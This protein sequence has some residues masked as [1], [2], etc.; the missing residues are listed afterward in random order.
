M[1]RGR[2]DEVEGSGGREAIAM[3]WVAFATGFGLAELLTSLD[4]PA[5]PAGRWD[6][7]EVP[8]GLYRG[9]ELGV[10]EAVALGRGSRDGVEG[11]SDMVAGSCVA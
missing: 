11:T 10:G 3:G 2:G 1:T 4:V 9:I 8:W 6:V 7:D 5:A